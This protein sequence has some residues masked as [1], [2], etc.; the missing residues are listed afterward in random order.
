MTQLR[1][2]IE[3]LRKQSIQAGL[4]SA[5]MTSM[6]IKQD[7]VTDSPKK[8]NISC[9]IWI[10]SNVMVIKIQCQYC[11]RMLISKVQHLLLMVAT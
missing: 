5:H 2:T 7:S 6:G 1:Q 11:F 8:V 10:L 3:L 4:T 9:S